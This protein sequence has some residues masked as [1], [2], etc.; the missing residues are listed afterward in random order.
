M[1]EISKIRWSLWMKFSQNMVAMAEIPKKC[2]RY[3]MSG[4][5]CLAAKRG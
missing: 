3:G 2:G 1:A 4:V 5:Q